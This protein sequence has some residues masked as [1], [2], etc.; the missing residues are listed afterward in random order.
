MT[1]S[2]ECG[3]WQ[4]QDS[5]EDSGSLLLLHSALTPSPQTCF[6]FSNSPKSRS[7]PLPVGVWNPKPD[8]GLCFSP[9]SW[10]ETSQ[11][12]VLK[13]PEGAPLMSLAGEAQSLLPRNTGHGK[14]KWLQLCQ[15]RPRLDIR[16]DPIPG[17]GVEHCPRLPWALLESPSLEM[18]G[19]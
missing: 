9:F 2:K 10:Q 3:V 12:A 19:K 4:S 13:V 18:L 1:L 15:G 17:G 5:V 11:K 14:R 6:A 8:L 16:G 7:V